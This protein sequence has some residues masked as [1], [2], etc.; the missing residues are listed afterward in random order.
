MG[1][2]NSR[3]TYSTME[4]ISLTIAITCLLRSPRA[5]ERVNVLLIATVNASNRR[6]ATTHGSSNDQQRREVNAAR[7]SEDDVANT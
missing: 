1:D 6:L 7:A 2:L 3:T 5:C 4:G